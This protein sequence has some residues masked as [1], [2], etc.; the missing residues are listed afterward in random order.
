MENKQQD[1]VLETRDIC[2]TYGALKANDHISIKIK[3]NSIHAIVGENG[4]GKSTLMGILTDIVKPDYGDIILNGEKVVF[5]SPMDAARHGIGMIYQEFMLAPRFTVLQNIIVGFEEKKG[6]FLDLKTCRERV[7]KICRDYHFDLPLD[8]M[9]DE[10][11][12]A[13]LQQIEIVKVLYRGADII[14]MD[15]PTSTLTPQGIEG[16]FAAMQV[17]KKAGK[18]ILFITHKLKEVF[19]VSDEIS[20]LRRGKFVGTYQPEEMNQQKLANLMVGREV[21]LQANKTPVEPG[22]EILRVEN[23]SVLDVDGI[24]RLKKVGLSI[25]AG[26]IV[27]IAGVAGSGQQYL[28][29]SI[30]G[31]AKAEPGSRVTYMG[32]DITNHTPWQ[33]RLDRIGYIPQDRMNV[34]CNTKASIWEN[35]IMG[36]HRAT[37]FK[38]RWLVNHKQ[39]NAFTDQV[40]QDFDVKVQSREDRISS[41]SG[42]NIQKLIVGREFSQNNRLLLIEDPTR[43]IDVGAIE[44]IWDKL[45][46]FAR[47][48][49]AVLLV[50]HEL[51]EVLQLSDR[52]LVMYDGQLKDGGTHG[53]YTEEQIGLL[54]TGG[55]LE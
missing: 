31:L 29:K 28:I 53:Q 15:E 12:V 51:N 7:E 50:S 33:N 14:I 37:G 39:A 20:V 45:L 43:G 27:G 42:G 35:A 2:K 13:V 11:P 19:Q 48:G 1:Y 34:G 25:R 22:E 26:E 44:Y 32:R 6:A 30:F 36:Y 46:A 21:I 38:P 9:I 8:E 4:A 5:K 49:A 47:E 52:I 17:L 24:E 40:V 18:T 23:L 54:M 16:L 41:L 3:R 10:L 55:D